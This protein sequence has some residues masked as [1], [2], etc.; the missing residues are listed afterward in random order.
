MPRAAAAATLVILA[1]APPL[2]SAAVKLT[3]PAARE[4]SATFAEHTCAHDKSCVGHGVLNCRRHSLHVAF[5]R[6]YL[7]R[8]TEVQ[9]SYRCS[10]LIRLAIDPRTHRVPVTGLGRWNC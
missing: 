10:R 6:I 4:K 1:L 9:G 8:D 7:R 3:I 2:A 5:C